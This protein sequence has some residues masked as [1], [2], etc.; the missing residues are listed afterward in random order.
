M[1]LDETQKQGDWGYELSTPEVFVHLDPEVEGSE[2]RSVATRLVDQR[3]A[4]DPL[5]ARRRRAWV[6]YVVRLWED[7]RSQHAL[8]AYAMVYDA[9]GLPAEAV[10]L[11]LG[12]EREH[13]DDLDAEIRS[14]ETA[15]A[16]MH[17]GEVRDPDV[18]VVDLPDG[19]A[20]RVRVLAENSPGKRRSLLIDGVSYWVPVPGQPD[21]LLLSFSTPV[22]VLADVLAEIADDI[23]RSLRF[24]R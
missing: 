3:A 8:D 21:I 2:L 5:I 18:S 17:E 1:D 13:P 16:V 14:L 7:A 12:S 6:K 11:V 20:V 22:L 19:P 9:E 24:T 23:A 4:V 10:L 15:L